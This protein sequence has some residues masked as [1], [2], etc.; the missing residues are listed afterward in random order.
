MKRTLRFLDRHPLIAVTA[1]MLAC[2]VIDVIARS[3]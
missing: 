2:F 1:G 3:L